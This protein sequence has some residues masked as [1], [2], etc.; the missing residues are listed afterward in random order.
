MNGHDD[1]VLNDRES[2][3][4]GAYTLVEPYHGGAAVQKHRW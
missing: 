3:V 1:V 2:N 4:N